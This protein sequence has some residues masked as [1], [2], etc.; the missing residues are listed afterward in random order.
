MRSAS[1]LDHDDE[2]PLRSGPTLLGHGGPGAAEVLA[3]G[4]DDEL[5]PS[6][7]VRQKHRS[8]FLRRVFC[9]ER[10]RGSAKVVLTAWVPVEP[11]GAG[12]CY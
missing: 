10:M 5:L 3:G 6:G 2:P 12:V 4:R 8:L 11:E 9:H 7:I 1:Q